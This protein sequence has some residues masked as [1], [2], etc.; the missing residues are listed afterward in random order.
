MLFRLEA[1]QRVVDSY[2]EKQD[3]VEVEFGSAPADLDALR[4]WVT[5]SLTGGTAPHIYPTRV[6]WSQQDYNKGLVADLTPFYAKP[7]PYNDNKIWG[8]T[9]APPVFE[10]L[11]DPTTGI[12]SSHSFTTTAVRIYYNTD[13]FKDLGLELPKTW[14]EFIDVQRKIKEKDII[15]FAFANAAP[16]DFHW[17]WVVKMM[18][19]TLALDEKLMLYDYNNDNN[20]NL[21]EMVAAIDKGDIDMT[22]PQFGDQYKVIKEEWM[23]Y[24][25]T[26]YNA[27]N[28]QSAF[29]MFLRGE[30]AMTMGGSFNL[31]EIDQS[32]TRKFEY[33]TF[34]LPQLL[35]EDHPNSNE[36]LYE[37]GAGPDLPL[38]VPSYVKGKEL[39]AVVDFLMYLSSSEVAT[40]LGNDINIV[41]ALVGADLPAKLSGFELAGVPIVMNLIAPATFQE[42]EQNSQ[43]LGQLYLQG[44]ISFEEFTEELQS[45]LKKQA[46]TMKKQNGWNEENKFG[47]KKE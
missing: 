4:T 33:G 44:D 22:K 31:K 14:S 28:V 42:T 40:A 7:N 47:A 19:N 37:L 12:I 46:E 9:I 45:I 25:A 21:N 34:P 20:L 3:K 8:E 11:K 23:P 38:S 39:D 27:L 18:Q 1:W 26:G 17:S 35:K 29:D 15:P 24:W 36:T 10:Q 30:A 32:Q 6:P 41:S 2:N 16:K 5:T 13:I 43:I